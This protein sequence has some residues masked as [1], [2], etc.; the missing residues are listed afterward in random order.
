MELKLFTA[1]IRVA[2]VSHTDDKILG[3]SYVVG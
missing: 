3:E 2:I 1:M